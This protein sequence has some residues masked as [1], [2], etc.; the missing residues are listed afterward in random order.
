MPENQ[1]S[2]ALS[3]GL[4]S[5]VQPILRRAVAAILSWQMGN[6]DFV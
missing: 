6:T 4:I 1:G 3:F 2:I 5:A